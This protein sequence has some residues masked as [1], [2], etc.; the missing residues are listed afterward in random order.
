MDIQQIRL[1]F[2]ILNQKVH[3]KPLVY[4]DNGATSQKPLEVINCIE[5]YYVRYNA[6]IHRGVHYLSQFA[7]DAYEMARKKIQNYLNAAQD[8][9]IIFTKGTTDGI[10][11]IADTFAQSI[12]NENDEVLISTMEHHSNIVPWQIA[13]AKSG[14]KLR[15]IHITDDGELDWEHFVSLVSENTKILALTHISNTLGTINPVKKYIDY[16]HQFNIPVL[17]DGAQSVQHLK[18]DV[19]DLDVDFYVFSGHKM[20]GPTGIGVL[21]G[22][23]FWLDQLPPYQGGGDMI[24]SVSFEKTIYNDLPHKFEAGTPNICGGIALGVAVDF[25]QSLDF[26][27][28]ALHEK[29]LLNYTTQEILTIP[30]IKIIGNAQDKSAVIS[31]I[32]EN[33]HHYDIGTLLDKMG[34]AVRT[35]HHCTEPLMHRMG[36]SGT[37]RASFACYNTLAEAEY[38]INSL[39]KAINMLV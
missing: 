13:C 33:A 32:H 24:K 6:N 1:Q 27:D 12:L 11:L 25:M 28:L 21:Y 22:K 7:T 30:G 3:H 34:V 9:E 2:P 15:V 14:A 38:F 19:Q 39:K 4:L 37:A 5:D 23:E 35:G 18:I 17:I 31:F 36:V 20:F 29:E 16:V 26:E 8:H 10:N